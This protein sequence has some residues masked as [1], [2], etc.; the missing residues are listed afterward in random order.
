MLP[1][2]LL[3]AIGFVNLL[4]LSVAN[5]TFVGTWDAVTQQCICSR[6]SVRID[7]ATVTQTPDFIETP[8]YS[9]L[10]SSGPGISPGVAETTDT[11][12]SETPTVSESLFTYPP[13]TVSV[14]PEPSDALASPSS[15]IFEVDKSILP[16]THVEIPLDIGYTPSLASVTLDFSVIASSEPGVMIEPTI[17][18]F[19]TPF[20][21]EDLTPTSS[22]LAPDTEYSDAPATS[23][24]TSSPP[25]SAFASPDITD[26]SQELY[27]SESPTY[28]ADETYSVFETPQPSVYP[29]S[30]LPVTSFSASRDASLA[31]ESLE[32]TAVSTSEVDYK[33]L[34]AYETLDTSSEPE[35]T[36]TAT[37]SV[38]P[39]P[40]SE[41]PIAPTSDSEDLERAT[42][43]PLDSLSVEAP[44]PSSGTDFSD[45]PGSSIEISSV[46]MS[47]MPSYTSIPIESLEASGTTPPDR[48]PVDTFTP[49]ETVLTPVFETPAASDALE[50]AFLEVS[51]AAE[52]PEVTH[53]LQDKQ[54]GGLGVSVISSVSP[55]VTPKTCRPRIFAYPVIIVKKHGVFQFRMFLTCVYPYYKYCR[56]GKRLEQGELKTIKYDCLY[57]CITYEIEGKFELD[58][59]KT[60]YLGGRF[61]GWTAHAPVQNI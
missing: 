7:R 34:P 1:Q 3:S 53:Y 9:P 49:F 22:T 30:E 26:A 61:S 11:I 50:G 13:S 15:E 14:Q 8:A 17:S 51:A 5:D 41:K 46:P 57:H 47:Q 10:V 27:E 35:I 48:S 2:L 37:I 6:R 32:A 38:L 28:S 36:T 60:F 21:E 59:R 42:G 16:T 18:L 44:T 4:A 40:L 25:T 58:S 12:D 43:I 23:I 55:T 31:A 20:S 52:S 54:E 29:T 33:L 24:D 19:P 56:I 45:M 39:T